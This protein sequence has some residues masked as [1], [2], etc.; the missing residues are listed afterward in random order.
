MRRKHEQNVMTTIRTQI[1]DTKEKDDATEV[2]WDYFD[3]LQLGS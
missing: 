3:S 1:N 2:M